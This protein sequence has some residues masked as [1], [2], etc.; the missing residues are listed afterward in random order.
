MPPSLSCTYRQALCLDWECTVQAGLAENTCETIK[1]HC[2]LHPVLGS[3]Q[4]AE[5][6]LHVIGPCLD[7]L[8]TRLPNGTTAE[9]IS[10]SNRD[11]QVL[12]ANLQS[13]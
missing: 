13:C 3:R 1:Q 6:V 4:K 5:L 10:I 9:A 12:E 2:T 7:A 8:G 11:Q